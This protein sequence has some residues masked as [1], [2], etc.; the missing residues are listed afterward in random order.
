MAKA[1]SIPYVMTGKIT[2]MIL[3]TGR[4]T[5]VKIK[6]LNEKGVKKYSQKLMKREECTVKPVKK[7]G[8]KALKNAK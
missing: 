1:K 4:T 5:K 8:T 7:G 6:A 3:S 2:K